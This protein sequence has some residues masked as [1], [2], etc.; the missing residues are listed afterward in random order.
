MKRAR[1]NMLWTGCLWALCVLGMLVPGDARAAGVWW[2]RPIV[3]HEWGVNTFDWAGGELDAQLPGFS[4]TDKAPGKALGQPKQRARDLPPDSGI[5]TKPIL[6]F[7]PPEK[8]AISDPVLDVQVRFAFG[9][10]AAWYPQVSTYRTPKQVAAANP[11]DWASWRRENGPF[12]R[13]RGAKPGKPVPEDERFE[14]VWNGLK[15]NKMLPADTSLA[16]DDLPAEHWWLKARDVPDA[17]YVQQ[18]K[19]AER[20][21]FYEGKTRELP[22][23]AVISQYDLREPKKNRYIVNVSDESIYDVLVIYRAKDGKC[24]VDYRHELKAAPSYEPPVW[25]RDGT[26]TIANPS[27]D[28]MLVPKFAKLDADQWLMPG[29]K[30]EYRRQTRGRLKHAMLGGGVLPNPMDMRDPADPQPPTKTHQLFPREAEVV[31]DIWEDDFFASDGLTII[32]RESPAYLDRAMPLN[33]FTDKFHYI[34]LSRC[35][36]VLNQHVPIDQVFEV[37]RALSDFIGQSDAVDDEV[38]QKREKAEGVL[39]SNRLMA[40]GMLTYFER[41]SGKPLMRAGE[42]RSAKVRELLDARGDE[43][44]GD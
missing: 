29:D 14:L 13:I 4:Y 37:D 12:E 38:R 26:L 21:L 33:I 23:T 32:Y 2:A 19:Q 27:T 1:L 35:G 15:L 43:A 30:D 40:L 42:D 20:F 24:W 3:V 6:Y 25:N 39:R 28:A 10:A 44:A 34:D 16:G 18:G 11:I 36:W 5:R 7:Y 9:Y 41:R 22:A 31:L 17:W 8:D